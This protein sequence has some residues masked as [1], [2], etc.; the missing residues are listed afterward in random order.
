MSGQHLE[1]V[2]LLLTR[3]ICSLLVTDG[4][5]MTSGAYRCAPHPQARL[6]WAVPRAHGLQQINGDRFE[7]AKLSATYIVLT[8]ASYL[9]W[10]IYDGHICCKQSPALAQE[11][12]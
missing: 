1:H 9:V 2:Y 7:K 4:T 6:V 5:F 11:H 12:V 8:Q 3:F 10:T